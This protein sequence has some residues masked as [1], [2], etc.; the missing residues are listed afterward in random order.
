MRG[1]VVVNLD[2]NISRDKVGN[3]VGLLVR[4]VVG[5]AVCEVVELVLNEVIK[6][7][8]GITVG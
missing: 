6:I 2:R 7:E 3:T 8:L 5:V 1:D 4:L